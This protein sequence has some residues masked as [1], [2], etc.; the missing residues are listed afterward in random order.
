MLRIL[1][2]F[3]NF[4]LFFINL[5]LNSNSNAAPNAFLFIFGTKRKRNFDV[6]SN[7]F[8]KKINKN[9]TQQVKITSQLGW[10][11]VFGV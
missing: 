3:N 4:F 1:N 7:G 5:T 2:I 9:M 6:L 11:T 8:Y 10:N